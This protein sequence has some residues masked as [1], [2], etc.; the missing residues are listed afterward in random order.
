MKFSVLSFKFVDN[1]PGMSFGSGSDFPQ[2]SQTCCYRRHP[3]SKKMGI[4]LIEGHFKR[5]ADL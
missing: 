4:N 2:A 3:E 1:E 5:Q